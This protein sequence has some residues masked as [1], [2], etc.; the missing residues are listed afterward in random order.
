M[1]QRPQD[2]VE[3][4]LLYAAIDLTMHLGE[5]MLADLDIRSCVAF[6]V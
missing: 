4:Y 3:M 1:R 2:D 5:N 6:R